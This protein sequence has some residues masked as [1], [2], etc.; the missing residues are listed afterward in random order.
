MVLEIRHQ[1][2]SLRIHGH[3]SFISRAFHSPMETKVH[4]LTPFYWIEMSRLRF[5]TI[6]SGTAPLQPFWDDFDW[7]EFLWNHGILFTTYSVRF[8]RVSAILGWL[9]RWCFI[10]KR[11]EKIRS[12][13]ELFCIFSFSSM[14]VF[15]RKLTAGCV[16]Y[17]IATHARQASC[18]PWRPLPAYQLGA[19]YLQ[20]NYWCFKAT[21][22]THTMTRE[23]RKRS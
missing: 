19:R 16:H 13:F 17:G 7:F 6:W 18:G 15:C 1:T 10:S 5:E 9:K 4:I 21:A 12:R 20:R 22:F 11:F 8:H 3:T 2:T 14:Q 23:G